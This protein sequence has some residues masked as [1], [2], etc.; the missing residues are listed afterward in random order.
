[1]SNAKKADK[2]ISPATD[3][4]HDIQTPAWTGKSGNFVNSDAM[5]RRTNQSFPLEK[6]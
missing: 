5:R 6:A 4:Q 1:L 3:I 2:S